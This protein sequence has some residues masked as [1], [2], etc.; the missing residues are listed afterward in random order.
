MRPKNNIF[1]VAAILIIIAASPPYAAGQTDVSFDIPTPPNTKLLDTREL[2]LGGPQIQMTI[3]ESNE[4]ASIIIFYY[5]NF[6]IQ[7]RFQFFK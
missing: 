5:R 4:A 3:Y 1:I 7:Q 6:F 2:S